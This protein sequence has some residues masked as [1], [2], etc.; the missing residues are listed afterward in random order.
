ML[1]ERQACI[2]HFPRDY[3]S[4]IAASAS[5]AA[6]PA[7][8][9]AELAPLEAGAET[10]RFAAGGGATEPDVTGAEDGTT[11]VAAVRPAAWN[12]AVEASAPAGAVMT[13]ATAACAA[14]VVCTVY[15][16]TTP[17]VSSCRRAA[18][19]TPVTV[20]LAAPVVAATTAQNWT[21]CTVP[22]VA[23]VYPPSVSELEMNTTVV[24]SGAGGLGLGGAGGGGAKGHVDAAR[25]AALLQPFAA[26]SS[27]L[28]QKL[29]AAGTLIPLTK[30][31]QKAGSGLTL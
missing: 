24:V 1:V 20:Q 18:A 12:A 11:D 9:A 7:P 4:S 26:H 15:A 17:L 8:L 23:T 31:E 14:G 30:L 6:A 28:V 2:R 29:A 3:Q 27:A 21:A 22:N 13:A 25:L 19:V 16:T 10:G 5:A